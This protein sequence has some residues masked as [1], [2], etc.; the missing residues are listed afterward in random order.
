MTLGDYG[1][2]AEIIGVVGMIASLIYVGYQL[3]QARVQMKGAAS[4][5]R[6][7]SLMNLWLTTTKSDIGELQH[8]VFTTSETLTAIDSIRYNGFMVSWLGFLQNTFYQRKLG[9]LD[10]DQIGFLNTLPALRIGRIRQYWE[11]VRFSGAYPADFVSHI[12][13]VLTKQDNERADK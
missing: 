2:L 5:A 10:E 12:D 6:A 11:Q 8:K 7:D 1:S 9:L 3:Q 4:Q 13:S